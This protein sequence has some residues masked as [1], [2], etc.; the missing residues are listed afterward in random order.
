MLIEYFPSNVKMID[1]SLYELFVE[2]NI[3]ITDVITKIHFE[4]ILE[5]TFTLNKSHRTSYYL[6]QL[7]NDYFNLFKKHDLIE[8]VS[9]TGISSNINLGAGSSRFSTMSPNLANLLTGIL[10]SS[11]LLPNLNSKGIGKFIK[12]SEYFR[13][14][15]Y[16]SGGQHFPHYD[17]DFE[18]CDNFITKYSLVMYHEDCNSGELYF[19]NDSRIENNKDLITDWDRQATEDEIYLKIKPG[20]LKLVIFPHTLCHGVLPFKEEERN[21]IRGD[22]IFLN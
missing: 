7:F 8:D 20:P 21:I 4:N 15:K 17:S 19:C 1:N 18:L 3:N 13:F 2:K 16:T 9:V 5:I 22:L 11:G 6:K 14:M 12:V 10:E